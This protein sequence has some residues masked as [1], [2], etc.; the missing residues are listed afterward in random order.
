MNV[1]IS[2]DDDY[3]Q[4]NRII[5]IPEYPFMSRLQGSE[6][7]SLGFRRISRGIYDECCRKACHYDE[8]ASYCLTK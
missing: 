5:E 6:M 1:I 7:K 3:Y 4:M 2:A 8:I